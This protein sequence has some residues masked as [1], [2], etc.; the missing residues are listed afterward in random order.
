MIHGCAADNASRTERSTSPAAP[1]AELK[2]ATL[3]RRL[4]LKAR[5]LRTAAHSASRTGFSTLRT[6]S[7]KHSA[8][9]S[10]PRSV[11]QVRKQYCATH[12]PDGMTDVKSIK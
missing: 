6:E 1:S 7:A 2:V 12:S 4:E 9:A 5:K 11:L 10:A 3:Y 8:A